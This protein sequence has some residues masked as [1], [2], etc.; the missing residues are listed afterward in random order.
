MSIKE[1]PVAPQPDRADSIQPYTVVG[2]E[3]ERVDGREKVSGRAE[4][5][6]DISL[7][8]MLWG[9][10]LRSAILFSPFLIVT[11]AISIGLLFDVINNGGRPGSIII[12]RS[13]TRG[14][15]SSG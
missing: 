10:V 13:E 8:G 2:R 3:V 12:S 11:A 5:V 4:Y 14:S 7:P 9:A 1:A 6:A 15:R